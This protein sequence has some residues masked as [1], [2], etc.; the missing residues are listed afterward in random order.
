MN[1][2]FGASAAEGMT[3]KAFLDAVVNARFGEPVIPSNS[4][5]G[6]SVLAGA[7]LSGTVDSNDGL[8]SKRSENQK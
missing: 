1:L 3:K 8:S 7:A 6:V 4:I 2:A 5:M